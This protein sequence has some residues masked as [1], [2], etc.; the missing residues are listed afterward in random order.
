MKPHRL[1]AYCDNKRAILL[2]AVIADDR[3]LTPRLRTKSTIH[4]SGDRPR[5]LPI[6]S[7]C[8][9]QYYLDMKSMLSHGNLGACMAPREGIKMALISRL[10]RPR[11]LLISRQFFSGVSDGNSD[12]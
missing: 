2:A 1:V 9:L 8:V 3:N 7:A 4:L 10:W 12:S 11:F 6:N 5:L